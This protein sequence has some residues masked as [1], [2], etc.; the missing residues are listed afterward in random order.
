MIILPS[1]NIQWVISS[2]DTSIWEE[3]KQ[4]STLVLT[5]LI[6]ALTADLEIHTLPVWKAL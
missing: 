3:Q 5:S 6:L 1:P 2:H 4:L